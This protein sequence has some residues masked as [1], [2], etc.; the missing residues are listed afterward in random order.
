MRYVCLFAL[1]ASALPAQDGAG[2]YKQRCASCHDNPGPRVPALSAIKEK[3]GEA[4]YRA[5]TS[6]TMKTQAQGL[7][8][9]EIL[10][11]I[12]YVGPSGDSHASAADLDCDM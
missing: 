1:M 3:S 2:I 5:L 7:S 12:S 8:T 9:G 10:A 11:L 6:G 4:I